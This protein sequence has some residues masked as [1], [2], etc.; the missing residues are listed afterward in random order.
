MTVFAIL[1]TCATG[2]LGRLGGLGRT[3]R[4]WRS[5][6]TGTSIIPG[7]PTSRLPSRSSR[8]RGCFGFR[9]ASPERILNGRP[10]GGV[11]VAPASRR[12]ARRAASPSNTRADVFHTQL[13]A[14]GPQPPAT[15][16]ARRRAGHGPDRAVG[17]VRGRG[18][19]TRRPPP[20]PKTQRPALLRGPPPARPP[21][22]RPRRRGRW[23]SA[24]WARAATATAATAGGRTWRSRW[25]ACP[26][27][28]SPTSA[29]WTSATSAKAVE[30]VVEEAA[31]RT[32]RRRR[33]CGTSADILDDKAVDA[34]V[35]A[36]PDHWHAPAAILACA[37]GKHVY[38]EKPCCHNAAEGRAA[39]RGGTQA[40]NASSSTAPSGAAGRPARGGRAACEAARSAG[41]SRPS[42]TTTTTAPP[43]ARASPP[44]VP[45]VARLVAV[46]GPGPGARIPR[47]PRPLQL[48]LVLALGHRRT[49][50]QRRPHDR[51]RPLG[52]GRRLP[53]ARHLRRRQV[54]L[55]RRRPGDAGHERRHVRVRRQTAHLGKPELGGADA[56]RPGLRCAVR[57]REG[58]PRS[59]RRPATPSTTPRARKSPRARA[60]AAT[61]ATS[62][63]S[64]TPSAA[65]ASSTR[66]SKRA[67]RSAC[68]ATSATSP[69]AVG[70]SVRPAPDGTGIEGDTA[71]TAMW[72]RE[73]RKG[74]EPK[75]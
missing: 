4:T 13:P 29:T 60:R 53:D 31:R 65:R 74:W 62:R 61:P 58:L 2:A 75:G 26:A 33:A 39:G 57:R 46:A 14:R 35:I 73:Y 47:Q 20:R 24:S 38:V 66:R 67:S 5:W 19:R 45:A 54:P 17:G 64:S 7:R 40:Q 56:A 27:S 48:A 15:A 1:R 51:R 6:R 41:C 30:S 70:R 34:M 22:R 55:P 32:R 36:T 28:R 21:G 50:Q 23:S 3:W 8:L 12:R 44:P 11:E 52:P 63:T 37:A 68:C 25:P 42:A 16:S 59:P 69:T 10:A 43:S 72:G 9:E 49:G 18:V 71:A